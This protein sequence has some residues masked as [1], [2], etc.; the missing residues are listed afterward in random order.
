MDIEFN[1]SGK[2]NQLQEFQIPANHSQANLQHM[3]NSYVG[4]NNARLDAESSF[5]NSG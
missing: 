1:R 3:S 5:D 2:L 4:Q